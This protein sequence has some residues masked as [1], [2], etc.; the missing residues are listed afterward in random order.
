ML[1]LLIN[2]PPR[3][4]ISLPPS[5]SPEAVDI[6]STDGADIPDIAVFTDTARQKHGAIDGHVQMI[7]CS[8]KATLTSSRCLCI[9]WKFQSDVRQISWERSINWVSS[10]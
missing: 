5:L 3:L 6:I 8:L 4:S 9:T 1:F 7:R 2:F 10:F